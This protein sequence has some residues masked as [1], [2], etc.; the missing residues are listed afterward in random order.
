MIGFIIGLFVGA[1]FGTVIVGLISASKLNSE[2]T[3]D[4]KDSCI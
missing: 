3:V 2:D 4:E 1:F